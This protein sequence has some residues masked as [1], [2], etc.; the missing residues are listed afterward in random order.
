[1]RPA[2]RRRTCRPPPSGG[3]GCPRLGHLDSR[4]VGTAIRSSVA[5]LWRRRAVSPGHGLAVAHLLLRVA[6]ILLRRSRPA[7]KHAVP[8]AGGIPPELAPSWQPRRPAPRPALSSG[9]GGWP[10]PVVRQLFQGPS[11]VRHSAAEPSGS[12][13]CD[14]VDVPVDLELLAV[15]VPN[16]MRS[17]QAGAAAGPRSGSHTLPPSH[18]EPGRPRQRARPRTRSGLRLFASPPGAPPDEGTPWWSLLTRRRQPAGT[19]E[20]W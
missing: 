7:Y 13:G 17:W 20:S 15:G 9:G 5:S 2:L 3:S 12:H 8:K 18:A 6:R 1:V 16:S 10:L 19:I 11:H 4:C 14:L